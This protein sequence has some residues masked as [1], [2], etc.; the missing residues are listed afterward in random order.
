MKVSKITLVVW[1]FV[2]P[3]S[4]ILIVFCLLALF[5]YKWFRRRSSGGGHSWW[6]WLF[7]S[8]A[9]YFWRNLNVLFVDHRCCEIKICF[10]FNFL[11]DKVLL[12]FYSCVLGLKLSIY[13]SWGLFFC[14]Y[15]RWIHWPEQWNGKVHDDY[16]GDDFW[17][18]TKSDW[19]PYLFCLGFFVF[20][21]N[22]NLFLCLF[23][24]TFF[25]IDQVFVW[26]NS[27]LKLWDLLHT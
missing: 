17:Q 9:E 22:Y 16:G 5:V 23:P 10:V 2:S 19:V 3:P 4:A 14:W 27:R 6:V 18:R 24:I 15:W 26:Q 8:L 21:P 11:V 20:W 12:G 13:I 25:S 1:V 7:L